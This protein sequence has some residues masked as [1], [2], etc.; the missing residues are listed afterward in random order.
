M[1]FED[2]VRPTHSSRYDG[3][4]TSPTTS[5][6]LKGWYSYAIAAEVFAVVGIGM[7]AYT[8]TPFLFALLWRNIF[9]CNL[10]SIQA[11]S[12]LCCSNNFQGKEVS[13]SL[14]DQNHVWARTD[15]EM[16]ISF[17]E[18]QIVQMVMISAS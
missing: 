5:R 16:P 14:T 4:D 8:L 1:S 12:Y 2:A 13:C 11:Y 7:D 18:E 9:H 10:I 17:A 3:E 6:E 15:P